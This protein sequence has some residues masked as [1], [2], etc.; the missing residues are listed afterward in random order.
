MEINSLSSLSPQ[1]N[2]PLRSVPLGGVEAV[3]WLKRGAEKADADNPHALHELA[4]LYE[5]ENTN[6]EIR[7]KVVADDSYA[8]QL[9][10]QAASLGYK[11]SQFRLGQA[12]E[13]GS[14]GCGIDN[15]TSIAYYTKAA[16]QGEHGAELALSG[17]YLTGA[18]GIL[19][20]ML[21]PDAPLAEGID[22]EAVVRGL[23]LTGGL[24]V[25]VIEEVFGLILV[26]EIEVITEGVL[27]KAAEKV[28]CHSHTGAKNGIKRAVGFGT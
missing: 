6:P 19:E 14:L 27:R 17:W 25:S 2:M 13:Y 10:E 28:A 3:I 9:F 4:Q 11:H 15:R 7:N 26:G 23:G 5:S 1:A 21:R 12:W 16:A 22:F 18:A 20:K 8:R 24:L